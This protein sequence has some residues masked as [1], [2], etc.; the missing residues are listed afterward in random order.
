MSR[1]AKSYLLR[2]AFFCLVLEAMLVPAIIWWPSFAKNISAIKSLAS[3]MPFLRDSVN[4]V[5][6]TGVAGYV[7]LQH[8]FKAGNTLGVTAAVLLAMGAI[9]GEAH[10]GT[11]EMW[12]A[13]P[14]T[15]TRLMTERYVMG[16]LA[17]VLPVFLTSCTIPWLLG[18]VDET[19][20]YG[21]LLLC[22]V[23]QS[24]FLA[25][26]YGMT[27][28]LSA[29]GSEPYRIAFFMLFLSIFEFAIY[30]VKTITHYSLFRLVD[31]ETMVQITIRD[32]LLWHVE[33]LFAGTVVAFYAA[34]LWAL[35]R[36][37]P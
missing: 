7:V 27:F 16:L 13:R 2:G 5:G 15:R 18:Y 31:I 30:L 25:G 17:L 26:V 37:V 9:A 8:F 32:S 4:L 22:S 36:R 35:K 20:R 10:R 21:T 29:I 14:V 33:A 12:L 11:L 28:F 23:H 6:E 34:S 3:P 19:M 1:D 24:L